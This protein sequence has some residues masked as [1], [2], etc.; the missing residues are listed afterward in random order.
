MTDEKPPIELAMEHLQAGDIANAEAVMENARDGAEEEFGALSPQYAAAQFNYATVLGALGDFDR[1]IEELRKAAVIPGVD[2]EGKALQLTA[3]LQLGEFL[4]R[5]GELEEAITEFQSTLAAHE[6]EYGANAEQTAA[7]CESYAHACLVSGDAGR[8]AELAER[9]ADIYW[10]LEHE[11]LPAALALRA[12][13]IKA[14]DLDATAMDGMTELKRDV[15][16]AF[17]TACIERVDTD[18]PSIA[19]A[20]MMDLAPIALNKLSTKSTTYLA[21]LEA[22][23]G[24]ADD[25]NEEDARIA[26]LGDLFKHQAA[27][28]DDEL[29]TRAQMQLAEAFIESG[30]GEK[31]QFHF[32]AA[33]KRAGKVSKSH[34]AQVLRSWG[35]NLVE[36]E[37]KQEGRAKLQLA[38]ETSRE[39][40]DSE[41]IGD[42]LLALGVF[43]QHEH[44]ASAAKPLLEGAIEVLPL[45]SN[46][47]LIA[48][49]HLEALENGTSCGC[50]DGGAAI[51]AA[52]MSLVS[53][54][55]PD[56]LLEEITL[57]NEGGVQVTLNREPTE[58]ETDTLNRAIEAAMNVIQ[59]EL[60]QAMDA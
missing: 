51:G 45:E 57:D 38:V 25:A 60:G 41:T 47:S 17:V 50:E 23:A 20:V 9:A 29:T 42:C 56:D 48:H 37:S 59:R 13:A 1:G 58:E 36:A 11:M 35:L 49:A 43:L 32:A 52:I 44:E 21:L 53:P 22:I 5:S 14:R 33:Q 7:A 3:R 30:D 31:A 18:P 8:A 24:A 4:A 10:K 16:D 15:F 28:G 6:A 19:L 12:T 2:T 26:A 55:V 46:E 54:H 40:P 34:E 27:L 39:G